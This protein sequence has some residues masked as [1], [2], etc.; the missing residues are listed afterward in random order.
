MARKTN[1]LQNVAILKILLNAIAL[2]PLSQY[3]IIELTGLSNSTVSRWLRYLNVSTKE[4]KN[5]VY[6]ADWKSGARGNPT[7]LWMLG[8]EM[9]NKPRPKPKTSTE[10]SRAWQAKQ[11]KKTFVNSTDK[12]L[13]H[14]SQ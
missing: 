2:R 13:I 8:Y 10:Y 5:L 6:I 4:S 1:T 11:L 9:P 14:V 12:G 3:Q 7:A